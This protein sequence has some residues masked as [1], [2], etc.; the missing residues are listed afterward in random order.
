VTI[1]YNL[2]IIQQRIFSKEE[3]EKILN[4]D[5]RLVTKDSDEANVYGNYPVKFLNDDTW[6]RNRIETYLSIINEKHFGCQYQGLVDYI[7]IRTYNI[8]EEFD[9]HTDTLITNRRLGVTI[10][11]SL[12]CE[13]GDLEFFTGEKLKIKQEVGVGIVFPII[14]H[15]RITPVTKG[16]RS[17]LLTWTKGEELNW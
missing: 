7:G 12:D 8:G 2:S 5:Y 9:W 11:L 13:G 15:H 16:S 3:C 10:P 6:V 1:L 17:T 14:Y 4:L